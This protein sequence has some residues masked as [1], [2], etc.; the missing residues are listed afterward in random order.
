MPSEWVSMFNEQFVGPV[1]TALAA[2]VVAGI[3]WIGAAL[4][5]KFD[6]ETTKAQADTYARDLAALIGAMQR[7]AV[8]EVGDTSTPGPTAEQ[9][10]AYLERVKPDLLAKM[11]VK[12]EALATMAQAAITTAEVTLTAPM[13]VGPPDVLIPP[14]R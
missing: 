10:V 4:K 13:V 12:P 9:I 3:G 11:D 2:A 6:A 5:R 7:K 1:F 8:A 14:A